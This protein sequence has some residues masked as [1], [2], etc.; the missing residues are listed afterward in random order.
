MT[1]IVLK[2]MLEKKRGAIINISSGSGLV[3]TPMLTLYS[4]TKVGHEV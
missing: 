3:P 1:K 4:G 2:G